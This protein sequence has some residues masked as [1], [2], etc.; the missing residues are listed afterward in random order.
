MS[1]NPEQEREEIKDGL[2]AAD[3]ATVRALREVL[4]ALSSEKTVPQSALDKLAAI[5][6]DARALRVRK[7]ALE[8]RQPPSEPDILPDAKAEAAIER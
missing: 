4:L 5:E 2:A 8:G 3:G 6:T 1:R 7:A